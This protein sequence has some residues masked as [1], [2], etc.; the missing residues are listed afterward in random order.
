MLRE[1][2]VI[3]ILGFVLFLASGNAYGQAPDSLWHRAYGDTLFDNGL[4]VIETGDGYYLTAG[5]LQYRDLES[6][7]I[8]TDAYVLKIDADG[9]TLWARRYGG[10]SGDVAR[11]VIEASD[12]NYVIAG[13]SN[14]WSAGD[15]DFYVIKIDPDGNLIW[16]TT[17]GNSPGEDAGYC[18]RE[19]PDSSYRIVGTTDA[20]GD[21]DILLVGV[22]ADNS[23]SWQHPYV[24]P[25]YQHANRIEVTPSGDLIIV[26]TTFTTSMDVYLMKINSMGD[27]L[28]T[29]AYNFGSHDYGMSVKPVSYYA[30]II[31][32][33]STAAGAPIQ[34]AL[35]LKVGS[36]GNVNWSK[37]YGGA[38]NDLGTS[39]EALSDGGFV[40]TGQTESYGA[41]GRDV[42]LVRTDASGD[43]LWTTTYG[44]V[45]NDAG[46]E[47][48]STSDGSFIIV[49]Q[50]TSFGHGSGDIYVLKT[51]GDPAG[52][53]PTQRLGNTLSLEATPVPSS[54]GVIF[55]FEIPK[56]IT[57]HL[58]VYD[59]HG[60]E[61]R[62]LHPSDQGNGIYR[63][64]WDGMDKHGRQVAPGIYFCKL[65]A[66]GRSVTRKIVLTR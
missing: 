24:A 31:S 17:I 23:W 43:T 51:A 25:S 47:V 16:E 18:V 5:S 52:I 59:L 60:R 10:G 21:T 57:A 7:E 32:G 42:W 50:T 2:A 40:F 22:A 13:Y 53:G 14:S 66:M 36:T 29:R 35:L 15:L 49:G 62:R 30:Y 33:Y 48:R 65:N 12:G 64:T 34:N 46:W 54:A 28:W 19:V 27:T 11:S 44:G 6:G 37:F 41:G 55:N 4:S 38:G 45:A 3:Y 26:G 8:N 1:H 63:G 61:V 56:N 39:V 9:D 58:T 20:Y